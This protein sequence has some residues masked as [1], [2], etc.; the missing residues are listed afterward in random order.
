MNDKTPLD[1]DLGI[2]RCLILILVCPLGVALNALGF[3]I[4][5][6]ATGFISG[7]NLAIRAHKWLET[8]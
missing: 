1:C 5:F 6:A 4:G 8:Y 2:V 3:V 7:W